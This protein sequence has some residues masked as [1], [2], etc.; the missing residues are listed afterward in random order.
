VPWDIPDEGGSKGPEEPEKGM[1]T[2]KLW[3]STNLETGRKHLLTCDETVNPDT[4]KKNMFL[5]I[6]G[7]TGD[8][9]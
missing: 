2:K 6:L 3:T 1:K 9:N 5:K 4:G 7:R 8:K